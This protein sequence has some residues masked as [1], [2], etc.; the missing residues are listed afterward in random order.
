MSSEKEEPKVQTPDNNNQITFSNAQV[1]AA[2]SLGITVF[3]VMTGEALVAG[4]ASTC[5][6]LSLFHTKNEISRM[7][8]DPSRPTE[9]Q[10]KADLQYKNAPKG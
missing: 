9:N 8:T 5:L 4:L 10:Q 7:K 3:S 2:F 1:A 6:A